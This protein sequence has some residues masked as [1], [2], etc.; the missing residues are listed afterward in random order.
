M[1]SFANDQLTG[2][3]ITIENDRLVTTDTTGRIKMFDISKI[4]FTKPNQTQEEMKAL[5]TNPW[6]INAHRKL[7]TTVEIIQQREQEESEEEDDD[8]ELPEGLTKEERVDWPDFFVLTASQDC[9][10][11]LHRLS[12][13][14]RIGQFAQDELWNIYDMTPYEKIRPNYVRDWLVEKKEKWKKL[15]DDRIAEGRRKGLIPEERKVEVRLSTKDQLRQLGINIG[16]DNSLNDSFGDDMSAGGGNND[17]FDVD[18]LDSDEEDPLQQ[19]QF[20]GRNLSKVG[21]LKKRDM[22]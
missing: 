4:D 15:M 2:V 20:K 13:G 6:F 1:N 5:V 11:L 7:I 8:F 22:T 10:V 12:N 18:L 3:A 16:I 9:D 17:Q 19:D 21:N 14:V